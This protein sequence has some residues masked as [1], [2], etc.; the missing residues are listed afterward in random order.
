MIASPISVVETSFIFLDII[1][2]FFELH[3]ENI[4]SISKL[5]KLEKNISSIILDSGIDFFEIETLE[6]KENNYKVN[7]LYQILPIT[8]KYT[9]Q[10]NIVGNYRT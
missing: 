3:S 10:I 8:P 7:V 2:K 1:S 5:E 6:K 4:F 9:N